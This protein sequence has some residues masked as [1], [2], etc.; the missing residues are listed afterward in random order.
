MEISDISIMLAGLFNLAFAIFH[1]FF[2]RIFRWEKDLQSLAKINRAIMQVMNWALM[3][4]FFF[5]AYLLFFHMEAMT[6]SALGQAVLAGIAI[7][8]TLR[9]AMHFPLFGAKGL[10]TKAFVLLCIVGASFHAFPLSLILGDA[11]RFL[12]R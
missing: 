11:S 1:I 8:W 7:F 2:G 9:A 6:N 10:G 5:F 3:V 4:I 12:L